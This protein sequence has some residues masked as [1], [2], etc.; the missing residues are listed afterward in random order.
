MVSLK[1]FL[2]LIAVA[3]LAL[4]GRRAKKRKNYREIRSV[5]VVPTGQM[6]D[7]VC[8][9]PVFA[10]IRKHMPRAKIACLARLGV[11]EEVFADSGLVDVFLP[12]RVSIFRLIREIK[13]FSPE[14]MLL[15]GPNF[16]FPALAFL[17]KV[18]CIIVPAVKN[19]PTPLETR[20]YKF[21]RLFCATFPYYFYKYAPRERLRVLESM[22]LVEEN[23][24]KHLA[25]SERAREVIEQI[26]T[27]R[28]LNQSDFI[29]GVSP[30]AGNKIKEWPEERFAELADYLIE[31]Y[32]A[33]I[34]IIG[35]KDE[36]KRV[37]K[38]IESSK[39]ADKLINLQGQLSI[40]ELKALI[41]RLNLFIGVDTG[42]IYIA[43]A[44]EVPTVDIVGPIDEREQPP[45]GPRNKVVVPP[46]PRNP[47][48]F[49]LDARVYNVEKSLQQV[50][51]I[52]VI[53]VKEQIDSLLGEILINK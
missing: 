50:L 27:N 35:S 8:N 52:G 22:G 44:F 3:I 14:V 49:V 11:V 47:E 2:I 42:P 25:Y 43:E 36:K 53:L 17:A 4:F 29:V 51:S 21:L 31:K 32:K 33:K 30:S 10:A 41:A 7:M 19:R 18:P 24:K 12:S 48:L 9:T 13:S 5:I 46:P 26:F 38:M 23:T 37:G 40:D 39:H 6:G 28:F 1:N 20:P 45:I 16:Y 34:I 15:T